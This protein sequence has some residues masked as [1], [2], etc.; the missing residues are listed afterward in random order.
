MNLFQMNF[1]KGSGM[2]KRHKKKRLKAEKELFRIRK[3]LAIAELTIK[4][5]QAMSKLMTE[6]YPTPL[7]G[8][9]AYNIKECYRAQIGAISCSTYHG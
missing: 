1:Y 3:G 4:T 9:M 6:N 2:K 8:L 5:C 7:K